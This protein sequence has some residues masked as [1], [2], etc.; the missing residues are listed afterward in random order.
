[1]QPR[2]LGM[3]S[4]LSPLSWSSSAVLWLPFLQVCSSFNLKFFC[5][6][7]PQQYRAAK[8]S[9]QPVTSGCRGSSQ[10]FVKTQHAGALVVGFWT[11]KTILKKKKDSCSLSTTQSWV[12][13]MASKDYIKMNIEFILINISY[14]RGSQSELQ[15]SLHQ[16]SPLFPL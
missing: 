8:N 12:F 11:S 16:L 13:V 7:V 14:P 10:A 9:P 15:A 1:M 2:A 4:N 3:L 6:R 5:L